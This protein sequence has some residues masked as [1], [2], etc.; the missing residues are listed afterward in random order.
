M[1]LDSYGLYT[2]LYTY[3]WIKMF[4]YKNGLGSGFVSLERYHTVYESSL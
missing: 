1:E 2:F 3:T 4:I